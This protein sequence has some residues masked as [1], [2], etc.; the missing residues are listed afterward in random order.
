MARIELNDGITLKGARRMMTKRGG[1]FRIT[2]RNGKLFTFKKFKCKQPNTKL[3]LECR[4]AMRE[5]NE[6]A[7]EDMTLEGRREYWLKKAE[8]MGYKTAMGCARAW[9]MAEMRGKEPGRK[10]EGEERATKIITREGEDDTTQKRET[11]KDRDDSKVYIISI[12]KRWMAVSR[13]KKRN[14]EKAGS[15]T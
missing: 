9:Y 1:S 11:K 3:Q 4:E 14:R 2:K 13:G 5:A 7:R 15:Q 8:E 10:R 6:R 12:G